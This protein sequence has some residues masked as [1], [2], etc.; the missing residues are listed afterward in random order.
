MHEGKGKT[1]GHVL[2]IVIAG[3]FVLLHATA[4]AATATRTSAFE[5]DP[6]TGLLSKEIV[7]PNNSNLCV[8]TT[9]GY[10][11]FGNVTN[12][13]TRNCAGSSGEEVAAAPSGDAIFQSRTST[14]AYS[15]A[16]PNYGRFPTTST[17]ALNQSET[18]A[19]D[20]KFGG[21]TSLTGPN[22][23]TTTW[24]YDGFGRKTLE[25]RADGTK[26]K[27][28][29]ILCSGVGSGSAS[30]PTVGSTAAKYYVQVT[31]LAADGVTPNGAWTRTYFDMLGREIRAETRSFSNVSIYSD[32]EYDSIGRA[33]RTSRPYLAGATPQWT[34]L[35]YDVL[36]RVVEQINPD[37]TAGTPSRTTI[38]YNGLSVT[39]TSYSTADTGTQ[40]R[41]ETRNSQGQLTQVKDTQNNTLSHT[42]DP[43]G[44]LIKTT[45]ALGNQTTLT[46]DL[47][48]RKTGMVDR[49]M[50]SWTYVYNGLGELVRQTDAKAQ[51]TTMAYDKL[52]RMTQ[53]NEP[54]LVSNWYYD[55]RFG[56]AACAKGIGK[57]CE[58]RA[59]NGYRRVI[60]YDS[61]GRGSN[62]A[63]Y[64]DSTTTP[65][66]VGTT[67]DS[68]GRVAT[69]TYPTGFAV[70]YVYTSL[71]YLQEVRRN[72]NNALLWRVD[73]LNAEGQITQQTHGNNV[74]T[75]NGYDLTSGR[76]LSTTAG[77][78]NGVQNMTYAYDTLGNLKQRQ[79]GNFSQVEN[80]QYDALNRLRAWQIAGSGI[81][82]TISKTVT[83]NAIG[84]ILTKSGVGTYTYNAS[85]AT[86][87]RP[88]AVA[89]IT[90]T[91]NGAINPT[92]TYD[93]NGNMTSGAG[94]TYTYTSYNQVSQITRGATTVSFSFDVDHQRV[95]EV[96]PGDTT[97]FVMTS[98]VHY[99][100]KIEPRVTWHRHYIRAY[101]TSVALYE[102]ATGVVNTTQTRYF[103]LDHLGS[104]R[105]ITDESG[106]VAE[107]LAYDP[108]GKRR[109]PNGLDS[110]S[111]YSTIDRGFTQHEHLDEVGL[112]HM[113]ARVY[114]P[115]LGRFISPDPFIENAGS[116]QEFNRYTYVNN[117]P[118]AYTDPTG[119]FKLK[120]WLKKAGRSFKRHWKHAF[121]D[122]IGR[123]IIGVTVAYFTGY[124]EFGSWGHGLL[125]GVKLTAE[126]AFV[127]GFAGGLASSA[128]DLKSAFQGGVTGALFFGAGE[129]GNFALRVAAHAAVG[130]V[131]QAAGGGG[132]G[133][134][135]AAA[136]FAVLAAGPKLEGKWKAAGNLIR[137]TVVGGTASVIAGGKF[138]NGAVTA[139]YSYLFNACMHGGCDGEDGDGESVAAANAKMRG[140]Q[141]GVAAAAIALADGPQFGPAD[142][143]A[144]GVL[145]V[146]G[147][148]YVG[149][150]YLWDTIVHGN[151][152]SSTRLTYVYELQL[153]SSLATLKYGIT[154]RQPPQGRYPLW[155]YSV[156]NSQMS[157]IADY[158]NRSMARSHELR[159]C[160]GYRAANGHLPPLSF[161][162]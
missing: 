60:T 85:G 76:L 7:E 4:Q 144:L 48:G 157:V 8:V 80:F 160:T 29:Y 28:E 103:H 112:I 63:T 135:A 82:G 161:R 77:A 154:S 90:G 137:S 91:V 55:T 145:T 21:V 151:S 1:V 61:L 109:L 117:N 123:V 68:H 124:F 12:T 41:T 49:D 93:A 35:S 146:G 118:L 23:L 128:G 125:G 141:L 27:W 122:E 50:G 89:S 156:T 133:D 150:G 70:K 138:A 34:T 159:L 38:A 51:V 111:V 83:Y 158:P 152:L 126:H 74:V 40:S 43:F 131:S 84:N 58:A 100:K 69:E 162:C 42:Y 143:A 19:F 99:E 98:G 129:I 54:D 46:Y 130:C 155:F 36:S 25:T 96:A 102:A 17:N 136:A 15:T 132:C 116:L 108:W 62:V 75:N 94:R 95:K 71:S 57:L 120:K 64:I 30:C 101:G 13:T 16:A 26:T 153:R 31:P 65:Y 59:D 52:G 88:H 10:D 44:N 92:F 139:A 81:S 78:A 6:A 106:A 2:P 14:T 33:W 39:T 20:S 56:G 86:S 66:N 24:T 142:A 18:K 148:I 140:E 114:D 87:T 110:D 45:D 113:N 104:I 67:Y 5:Y 37:H 53:R 73:A 105:V 134:G 22:G 127:G 47:R 107:R 119:H 121:R 11:S 79:D 9:Y 149:G 147:V 3:L 97:I 115:L 32:T 72:D